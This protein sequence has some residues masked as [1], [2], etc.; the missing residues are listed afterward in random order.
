MERSRYSVRSLA[1]GCLRSVDGGHEHR[2]DTVLAGQGHHGQD[3]VDVAQAP[4]RTS[5]PRSRQPGT[6]WVIVEDDLLAGT[7]RAHGHRQSYKEPSFW[8]SAGAR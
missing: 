1:D 4:S 2:S 7:Q 3:A 5:A 8:I 6:L